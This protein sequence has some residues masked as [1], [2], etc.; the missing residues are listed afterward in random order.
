[1]A[2]ASITTTTHRSDIA[3]AFFIFRSLG[4]ELGVGDFGSEV[5]WLLKDAET[6]YLLISAR[7]LILSMAIICLK[8]LYLSIGL[9]NM[10]KTLGAEEP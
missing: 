7:F 3:P 6:P 5:C 2:A 9:Y 4:V 8:A 1:M 10:T